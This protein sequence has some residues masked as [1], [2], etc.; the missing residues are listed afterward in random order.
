[1]AQYDAPVL[2]V[3]GLRMKYP[4]GEGSCQ[5][6]IIVIAAAAWFMGGHLRRDYDKCLGINECHAIRDGDHVPVREG[7]QTS[8]R[9]RHLLAGWSLPEHGPIEC[10]GLHVEP[11]VV[12]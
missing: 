12:G 11:P 9:D 5:A 10:A 3:V 8:R 4:P 1:M 2:G 7:D 6:R